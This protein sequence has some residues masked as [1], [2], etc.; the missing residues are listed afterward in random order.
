ME[1]KSHTEKSKLETRISELK[2]QNAN[3]Q[4]NND[5]LA[6]KNTEYKRALEAQ[7]AVKVLEDTLHDAGVNRAIAET[8]DLKERKRLI[9]AVVTETAKEILPQAK[10]M[11]GL[12]TGV[13]EHD[14]AEIDIAAIPSERAPRAER[15]EEGEPIVRRE[16]IDAALA[17]SERDLLDLSKT[18]MVTPKKNW[19]KRVAIG[20]GVTIVG[21]FAFWKGEEALKYVSSWEIWEGKKPTTTKTTRQRTGT[22]QTPQQET[23]QPKQEQGTWTL[24]KL[25]DLLTSKMNADL[26]KAPG[27]K[28]YQRGLVLQNLM[29]GGLTMDEAMSVVSRAPDGSP[30]VDI[31][32]VRAVGSQ[33]GI[34]VPQ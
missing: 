23:Q 34:A 22:P 30:G 6:Q 10:D 21:A 15:E 26:Q 3:L 17:T 33:F 24:D 7:I 25:R 5:I 27:S 20:A 28:Y 29:N 9:M 1:N 18:K 12:R 16:Q 2:A 8:D 4:E 19:G 32:K 11:D 14:W 13:K 31:V